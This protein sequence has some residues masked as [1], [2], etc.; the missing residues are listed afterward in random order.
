MVV[1]AGGELCIPRGQREAGGLEAGTCLEDR[2]AAGDDV[3]ARPGR[4][5]PNPVSSV[6]A[7]VLEGEVR[8]LDRF[9]RARQGGLVAEMA[10]E[11]GRRGIAR[12][13]VADRHEMGVEAEATAFIEPGSPWENGYI[14]SFNARLRDELLNGE[15]FYTLKEARVL[16]ESW[17]RHYNPALQHPSVYAI[18]EKRFC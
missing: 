4:E 7:A 16:V 5:L 12:G 9:H 13:A 15:I 1:E 3:E 17:R 11:A 18:E 10:V 8:G 6:D 14:E 2:D